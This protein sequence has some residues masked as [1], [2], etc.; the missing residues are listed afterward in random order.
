MGD[1]L[2][3]FGAAILVTSILTSISIWAPRRVIVRAAAFGLAVLFVP[4]SYASFASLL[5]KPKPV[6][7]EWIQANTQEASV[8]GSSIREGEAIYIW[9]QMP[10]VDEPRAYTLPWNRSVA[11]QLQEARRKAEE[12]GTGLGMRL[13]FEHSWDKQEPTFYPLPQPAMPPKD[14]PAAPLQLEHPSTK[15]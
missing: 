9:L 14:T 4:L 7:L 5:S 8:L 13:P 15:A 2:Y 6:A 12:Q 11:N 10:G 3:L 1:L